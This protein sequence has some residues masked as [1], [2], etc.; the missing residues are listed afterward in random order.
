MELVA[1][2]G[3]SHS[4]GAPL[5]GTLLTEVGAQALGV[6]RC[7]HVLE[8]QPSKDAA[9]PQTDLQLEGPSRIVRGDK[10]ADSGIYVERPRNRVAKPVWQRKT[11]TGGVAARDLTSAVSLRSHTT[12]GWRGRPEASGDSAWAF[13]HVVGGLCWHRL[14]LSETPTYTD[15]FRMDH[16]SKCEKHN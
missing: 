13:Q 16:S 1:S 4:P 9:S 8:T 3:E 5:Y 12:C 10:Q 11:E 14:N 7:V 6:M 2:V 15:E